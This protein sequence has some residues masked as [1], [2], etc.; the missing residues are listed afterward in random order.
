MIDDVDTC[1]KFN[2]QFSS[3]FTA[4]FAI[5]RGDDHVRVGDWPGVVKV[6]QGMRDTGTDDIAGMAIES[7]ATRLIGTVTRADAKKGTG[8]V[9]FLREFARHL[10]AAG[11]SLGGWS[12]VRQQL[13]ILRAI[14]DPIAGAVEDVNAHLDSIAEDTSPVGLA[15]RGTD[16]GKLL[17]ESARAEVARRSGE[18]I[19]A[20][21]IS[22][23]ELE[24]QRIRTLDEWPTLDGAFYET[25]GKA[26]ALVAK[27]LDA[28]TGY[29][30]H[31]ERIQRL[32]ALFWGAGWG[33]SRARR[34]GGGVGVGSRQRLPR[35]PS[36]AREVPRSGTPSVRSW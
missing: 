27:A 21:G 35:C 25:L 16:S 14:T 34:G 15:L 12:S 24:V 36:R 32:R 31:A 19:A 30:I 9:G 18:T 3:T 8:T 28:A 29:P 1:N 5:W 26:R 7:L 6:Y 33:R 2:V 4:R 20:A 13:E 23:A 11:P 17:L 22:T 10:C